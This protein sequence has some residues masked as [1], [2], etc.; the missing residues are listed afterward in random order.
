MFDLIYKVIDAVVKKF[1]Q[2][3]IV[4]LGGYYIR[5]YKAKRWEI[6]VS[7]ISD[8]KTI[9]LYTKNRVIVAFAKK[10]YQNND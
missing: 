4:L 1:G 9:K 8:C 10:G 6:V 7:S 3:K 5:S 2:S